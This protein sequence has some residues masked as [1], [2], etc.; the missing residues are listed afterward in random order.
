VNSLL[1][2]TAKRRAQ[3]KW[4]K[5]V[6]GLLEV[7]TTSNNLMNEILNAQDIMLTKRVLDDLV[8]GQRNALL[9]DSSE[10]TLV[11]QVADGFVGRFTLKQNT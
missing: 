3:L 6:V 11:D 7:R 5:E 2:V 8:V 1:Y 9:V 10:T 4:P